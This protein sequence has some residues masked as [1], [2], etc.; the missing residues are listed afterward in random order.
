MRQAILAAACL[1]FVAGQTAAQQLTSNVVHEPEESKFV[2]DDIEHF[3]EAQA[4]IAGG[5]DPSRALQTLY[6]DRGSPGLGM[7]VEKYDLTVERLLEA[8]ERHPEAYARIDRTL[9]ALEERRPSFVAAY[10]EIQRILPGAVFPPTYFVAAGHRGIGS[11]SV[12]GPLISIEK[13]TPA[14]VREGDIEPTLVHEMIHIEQLAAVRDA[15][16]DIFSGSGR[17]LLANSIREGGATW[18][19]ERI[20][21]G[22]RHKNEARDYYL[23][24]EQELWDEY[25]RD[26]YETE[27]GDWLWATPADPEQPRDLGYAIGARIVQTYY[28]S[29]RD[30]GRAAMEIMAITDYPEFLARS[31]YPPWPTE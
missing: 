14:S 30:R 5:M 23:A 17:T 27:M 26:M 11:G 7:F 2:F 18:M 13:N 31:G 24:R 3:L 1:L 15:Y 19:A 28:E 22:S 29:A 9:A 21:G 4:A 16:F 20:T 6:I 10:A 8:M 25:S 12:E